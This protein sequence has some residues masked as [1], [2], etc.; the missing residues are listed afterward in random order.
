MDSIFTWQTG[1]TL[2]LVAV[3]VLASLPDRRRLAALWAFLLPIDVV[4]GVPIELL[5]ALRYGGA[6]LLAILFAP[7]L[8]NTPR[9]WFRY[10]GGALLALAVVRLLAA[11][12]HHDANGAQYAVV[13][14]AAT[15]VA[16]SMATRPRLHGHLT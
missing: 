7:T 13:L 12:A 2:A 8:S 1:V 10:L 3:G 15:M 14:A 4:T 9:R 11:V 5:D 6:L 16:Y